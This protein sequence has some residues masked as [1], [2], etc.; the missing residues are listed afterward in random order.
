M[1]KMRRVVYRLYVAA[2]HL[3]D[4]IGVVGSI[5]DQVRAV[6]APVRSVSSIRD[7]SLAD[8]QFCHWTNAARQR[9][10]RNRQNLPV[11]QS[12][13]MGDRDPPPLKWSDLRYVFDIQEDCNGKEALQA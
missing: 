13:H 9:G 8:R 12:K 7:V 5:P 1:A 11:E 10:Q 6:R 3:A 2:E 4:Q